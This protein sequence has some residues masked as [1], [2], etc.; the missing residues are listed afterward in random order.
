MSCISVGFHQK[1]MKH[2]LYF[3]WVLPEGYETSPVFQLDS[4]R[5][6]RNMSC[7]SVGFHQKDMN[8]VLYFSGVPPE[9]YETCPVFPW[10]S[11][12]RI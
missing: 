11:T 3:S 12:R 10:G 8:H 7:I 6:I 9:G 4:T 5:R 1:D 2:V